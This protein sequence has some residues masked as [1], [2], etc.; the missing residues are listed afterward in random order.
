MANLQHLGKL[1]NVV[2]EDL[3]KK[4]EERRS[5]C[6]KWLKKGFLGSGFTDFLDVFIL[7]IGGDDA[8]LT[9]ILFEKIVVDSR[10]SLQTLVCSR[11]SQWT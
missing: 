11:A 1:R 7:K 10:V 4:R 5:V 2:G 9:N 6:E 8:D 3:R